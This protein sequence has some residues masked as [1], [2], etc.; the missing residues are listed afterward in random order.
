MKIL[1]NKKIKIMVPVGELAIVWYNLIIF[2]MYLG[3]LKNKKK[4]VKLNT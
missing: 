1:K 4:L 2:C 3:G